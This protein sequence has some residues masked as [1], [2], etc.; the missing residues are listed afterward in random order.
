MLI[1]AIEPRRKSLRALYL[2]GELAVNIDAQTL[3]ALAFKWERKLPT[4][5]FTS[6]W[7]LPTRTGQ[8]KRHSI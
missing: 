3:L 7:R 5:S 8:R 4:R 2:D 1:T 6:F